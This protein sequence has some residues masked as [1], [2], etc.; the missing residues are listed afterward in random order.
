MSVDSNPSRHIPSGTPLV[1]HRYVAGPIID[2]CS[3]AVYACTACTTK[4]PIMPYLMVCRTAHPLA[5]HA[6]CT[7]L[8]AHA[9]CRTR[10]TL[11][12]RLSLCGS[13]ARLARL[14]IFLPFVATY[15]FPEQLITD[16]GAEWMLI[17]FVCHLIQARQGIAGRPMHR[18][19]EE[20][21]FNVRASWSA[22][23]RMCVHSL[24]QLLT[25]CNR[26]CRH[27]LRSSCMRSTCVATS[28]SAG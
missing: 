27:A 17:S 10:A 19:V 21:K 28:K 13:R 8:V 24:I 18:V 15:G 14:Q 23:L 20:S 4:I 9:I 1:S 6:L 12:Q 22:R 2:G 7:P 25:G 16:R 3:R 26:A 5:A 11:A